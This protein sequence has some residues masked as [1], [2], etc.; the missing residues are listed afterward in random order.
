LKVAIV[1][2]C[3]I[4]LL[5]LTG[6]Q[7]KV[8]YVT[9]YPTTITSSTAVQQYGIDS[10]GY[11]WFNW[12]RAKG[13][14]RTPVFYKNQDAKPVPY[15][16]LI[17]FLESTRN[18]RSNKLAIPGEYDC[19]DYTS[20][21][22]NEAEKEGIESGIVLLFTDN[23]NN[24]A[25]NCFK[26]LDK[27]IIYIDSIWFYDNEVKPQIGENYLLGD[28]NYFANGGFVYRNGEKYV[29]ENPVAILICGIGVIW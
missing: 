3:M 20:T 13:S 14:Y 10:N 29:D 2:I 17:E 11:A 27:G 4:L 25:I 12:Q 22:F 28:G 15:D 19:A 23:S 16:I 9:M 24:H 6:C 18:E 8:A 7:G 26:T 21:L 1:L 5:A